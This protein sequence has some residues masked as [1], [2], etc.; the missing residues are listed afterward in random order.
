[1]L[2]VIV[3]AAMVGQ[4]AGPVIVLGKP[5]GITPDLSAVVAATPQELVDLA[6]GSD[7]EAIKKARFEIPGFGTKAEV[8]GDVTL[9]RKDDR[10]RSEPGFKVKV[11]DGPHAGLV[12]YV[13]ASWVSLDE[14]GDSKPPATANRKAQPL[15][16][17][18]YAKYHEK[19]EAEQAEMARQERETA[20]KMAPYFAE[21][22]RQQQELEMR[23]YEN[24]LRHQENMDFNDA[25]RGVTRGRP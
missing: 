20:I 21:Q 25:I 17:R 22:A 12:G 4:G 3:A 15:R 14:S 18:K 6:V 13:R 5:G 11:I 7:P 8:I 1:M 10:T 16:G 9:V 2:A 19:Y 24:N 23:L